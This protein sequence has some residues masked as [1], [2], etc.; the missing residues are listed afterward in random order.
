MNRPQFVLGTLA[1]FAAGGTYGRAAG[2]YEEAVGDLVLANRILAHENVVDA[3][4]HV[5]VRDPRDSSRYLLSRSIA[6]ALVTYADILTYTLAGDEALDAQGRP[7]YFERF[8]HG[9]IYRARPDVNA[10]VHSHTES[11][12]PFGVLHVPLR[13]IFHMAA[14]LG[15]DVPVFEIRTVAGDAT[16][17]LIGTQTLG[18]A[19]ARTLGTG[20]VALMRGHGMVAVAGTVHEAVFRAYYTGRDAALESEA[21]RL[22]DPTFLSPGEA[23]AAAATQSGLVDRSWDLWKRSLPP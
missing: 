20:S 17:L 10:V 4:G 11:V 14:F 6:P 2:T 18:D 7:S 9:A 21:L 19:L 12:I 15:T 8:I 3:F 1:A 5:S 22:G 23:K 16:S 13:P